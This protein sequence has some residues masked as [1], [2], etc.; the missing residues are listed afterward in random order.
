LSPGDPVRGDIDQ[1]LKAAQRATS[2]TQR[3]LTFSRR[4]ILSARP[5]D[6]NELIL[7]LDK[8]LRR[9]IG[10]DVEMV[11]IP[12]R[13]PAIVNVDPGQIE[14][15]L[16]NLAVNARDAMPDG[17]KLT[18]TTAGVT[19]D[20]EFVRGHLGARCGRFVR[21]SIADTGSGM[22]SEVKAHLFEPF[23]TTKDV[24][25][26][27]GLGLAAVYGIVGHHQGYVC[28]DSE[29]GRGTR[30]DIY[31][32]LN[33]VLGEKLPRRDEDGYLPRGA[34]TV[35]SVEDEPLVRGLTVR[36]LQ[37]LGYRVLEAANGHEALNVARQHTGPIDLLLTDVVMPQM[38]GKAL[39]SQ[40][41]RIRP[42]I[43]VLFTSGYIDSTMTDAAD[44]ATQ[45]GFLQK[46][47]SEAGLARKVRDTLDS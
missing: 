15:A 5:I 2:L 13:E 36:I 20:E 39:A 10:E 35:L 45:G 18:I 12:M 28:V 30:V 11:T 44:L 1:V 38:S 27:T 25:K 7:D 40:L 21:L 42:E 4:H 6:L 19:L 3:L 16:V 23:F 31:L 9:L 14:Q 47:F 22:S 32:L 29:L 17:G 26:G 24:G 41:K 46:P 37:D 43:R 8:M 33:P 34:E